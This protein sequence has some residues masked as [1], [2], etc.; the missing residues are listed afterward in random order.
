MGR[1]HRLTKK[2][3]TGLGGSFKYVTPGGTA[4]GLNPANFLQNQGLNAASGFDGRDVSTL[5]QYH[6]I[7]L[8]LAEA[9]G[10]MHFDPYML[11]TDQMKANLGAIGQFFKDTVAGSAKRVTLAEAVNLYTENSVTKAIGTVGAAPV[12]S[13]FNGNANAACTLTLATG[14]IRRGIE[15]GVMIDIYTPNAASSSSSSVIS[16]SDTGP[17]LLKVNADFDIVIDDVDTFAGRITIR[18]WDGASSLAAI[19]EGD[20]IVLRASFGLGPMGLMSWIKS[21]S[22]TLPNDRWIFDDAN[23]GLDVQAYSQ[24]KSR[25]HAVNGV[26]SEDLWIR[27][28]GAY[29][30]ATNGQPWQIDTFLMS[31][32]VMD[33]IA[34]D[35]ITAQAT[36][37]YFQFQRQG[38]TLKPVF[39]YQHVEFHYDGKTYR[40]FND[41]NVGVGQVIGLKLG[42]GNIK[43]YVPPAVP[44]AGKHAAFPN[45]VQFF[46]PVSGRTGIWME[47]RGNDGSVEEA[48]EAPYRLTYQVAPDW[49]QSLLLTDCIEA[50]VLDAA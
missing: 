48:M 2:F 46:G 17:A 16:S 14:R 40:V 42:D 35:M 3:Q 7:T 15:V 25:R 10:N 5:P 29:L 43:R 4:A 19:A 22:A 20:T 45:Q 31:P 28:I 21:G 37:Q 44:G 47:T 23:L 41:P 49:P 26:L 1:T 24:H 13:A 39:G 32:G 12:T 36:R 9:K 34:V 8:A 33:G 30:Y 11:Q 6:Q 50:Q 27:I 38:Q 18:S